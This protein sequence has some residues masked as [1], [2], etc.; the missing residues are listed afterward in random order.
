VTRTGHMSTFREFHER[1][2][3]FCGS[4]CVGANTRI[5]AVR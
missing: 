5:E 2:D 4:D 3:M 1:K